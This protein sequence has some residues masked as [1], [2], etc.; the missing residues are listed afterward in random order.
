MILIARK[1]IKTTLVCRA[2]VMHHAKAVVALG[3]A[4]TII[5]PACAQTGFPCLPDLRFAQIGI[6]NAYLGD[7]WSYM[8]AGR[9]D[10]PP[11]VLLH[12]VGDT[13]MAWRFQFAGLS[14]RFRV[15]A[16]NAPG[17]MLSDGF[18]ME[19]P[20]CREYA[21]ALADFLNAL[22]LTRVNLVGNSFGSRVAQCFAIH[23]PT[24]VI[25]LIM[26]AMV[27]G[28][29]HL[30]DAPKAKIIAT[31]EAQI[32]SGG[33]GFGARVE[34]LLGPNTSP[35]LRELV[36]NGVRATNRRGFLQGVK[37]GFAEGYSP[38]EVAAVVKIPVMMITGSEDRVTPVATNAALLKKVLPSARLEILPGIGH[39]PQIEAPEKV[40]QLIRDF[41]GQ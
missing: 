26:T 13:S 38:A 2:G 8:E 39:L 30:S 16:W 37:L 41:L 18:K 4:L 14:D 28:P 10:S 9:V 21:D 24:R 40:N 5:A 20:G 3:V 29:R 35:E 23:H 6:R 15:V 33:Y 32:A 27:V 1:D 36:R 22:A 34:A 7:R 19:D 17:Y 11:V 25:K 12:G 31:R